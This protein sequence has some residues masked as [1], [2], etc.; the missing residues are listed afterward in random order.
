MLGIA[1]PPRWSTLHARGNAGSPSDGFRPSSVQ[2]SLARGDCAWT[3]PTLHFDLTPRALSTARH[4]AGADPD[5]RA[6]ARR[7]RGIGPLH[8]VGVPSRAR[9]RR[10][11]EQGAARRPSGGRALR[12]RP[13]GQPE[14]GAALARRRSRR[15]V[16]RGRHR[17]LDRGG[18][19]DAPQGRGRDRQMGHARAAE[20]RPHRLPVA[21]RPVHR[22]ERGI[23]L[24][25]GG[26]ACSPSPRRPARSPTTSRASSTPT[27]ASAARSTPSFASTTSTIR[28]S[29]ISPPSCAA[30]TR[31]GTTWR[32]N[33]A[34]C[35]RSRSGSRPISPT[36]TRCCARHGHVRRALHLVPRACRRRRT[37]GRDQ[38]DRRR[39]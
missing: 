39:R 20:D 25:A 29:T 33:A 32:R 5:R 14:R 13:S 23:H 24:R 7:L 2:H 15:V 30:P 11:V 37:T 35:S 34:A 18:A 38:A 36:T 10:A 26:R 12:A 31:R 1:P 17:R 21:D 19:A 6:Q 9:G 16:S 4:R 28:R 8:R 27:R 22:S 3:A